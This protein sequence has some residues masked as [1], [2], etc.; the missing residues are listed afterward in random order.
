[1][2]WTVLGAPRNLHLS[3]TQ[4]DPPMFQATWQAPR[5]PISPILGYRVQYGVRGTD[6]WE[7]KEFGADRYRFTT[8]FLGVCLFTFFCRMFFK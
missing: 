3:L 1:M 5:N 8:T 6:D 7:T 4:D 2:L